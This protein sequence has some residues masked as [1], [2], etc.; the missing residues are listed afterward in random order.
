MDTV[1]ENRTLLLQNNELRK[2]LRAVTVERDVALDLLTGKVYD[3][4]EITSQK[5]P[6]IEKDPKVM[7]DLVYP[8]TYSHK[9]NILWKTGGSEPNKKY[10]IYVVETEE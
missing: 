5:P 1:H 2:Q 9:A 8:Q 6:T 7:G 4:Y 10:K 3:I